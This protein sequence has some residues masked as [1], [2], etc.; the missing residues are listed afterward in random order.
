MQ[1]CWLKV[2]NL[3][4]HIMI[5]NSIKWDGNNIDPWSLSTWWSCCRWSA[6]FCS[7]EWSTPL[8]CSKPKSIV[9]CCHERMQQRNWLKLPNWTSQVHRFRAA[10]GPFSTK[11]DMSFLRSNL[12]FLCSSWPPQKPLLIANHLIPDSLLGTLCI[13]QGGKYCNESWPKTCQS[14]AKISLGWFYP[15]SSVSAPHWGFD[16]F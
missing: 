7:W 1:I 12:P 10:E 3:S 2:V 9:P 11:Q 13:L 4:E 15:H 14:F 8:W 6:W 16:W 5:S